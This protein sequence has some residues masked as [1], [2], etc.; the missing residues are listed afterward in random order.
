ME[1]GILHYHQDVAAFFRV[2]A[3]L[4]APG[5]RM[6]LNEFHP[7]RMKLRQAGASADYF[8]SE[9]IVGD[10]PNPTGGPARLGQCTLRLWTLG[11]VVTAAIEAGFV[12]EKLLELPDWDDPLFPGMYTLVAAKPAD[13]RH[14]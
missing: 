6:V 2:M 5:G 3:Y 13:P 14:P 7:V 11:E 9:P 12:V 10:V 8:N 4:L 1:L